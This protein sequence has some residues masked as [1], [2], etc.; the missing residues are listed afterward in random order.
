MS[1]DGMKGF[2][3]TQDDMGFCIALHLYLTL[4]HFYCPWH[5]I[6]KV[7]KGSCNPGFEARID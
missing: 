2:Q 5:T 4:G 3:E 7:A 6:Q 1:E